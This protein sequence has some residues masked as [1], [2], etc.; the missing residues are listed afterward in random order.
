MNNLTILVDYRGA[1]YSS[2]SNANTF[3]SMDL[4]LLRSRFVS[5]GWDVKIVEFPDIDFQ[6]DWSNEVVLYQSAEDP[7]LEYK[8]YIEDVILG[9][10]LVGARAIPSFPYLRA[11]HNKVFME[12]LRQ[13]SGIPEANTL[14]SKVFGTYEDFVKRSLSYPAVAKAAESSG[15]RGVTL[16]KNP[17]EA[18]SILNRM[19]RSRLDDKVLREHLKRLLRKDYVPYS[20][21]RRKVILQD[22]I[23][24]LTYDY[25]VLVYGKQVYIL[26]RQVRDN[27]FRASGSGKFRWPHE[28]PQGFLDFV[29][30]LFEGFD[31]P[32]AS[33]DIAESKGTF[34][35]LEAQFV[36][37][38]PLTMEKSTFHWVRQVDGWEL[39]EAHSELESTFA[40]GISTYAYK[41]GWLSKP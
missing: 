13:S 16:I 35:L 14:S 30:K 5:I 31:V 21:N 37:F 26:Q 20:L 36:D 12:I 24:D 7:G 10:S 32:N 34:Y 6:K 41:K 29:W 1:F 3:C 22:Y 9:L 19:T 2:T 40:D 38:G 18:T 4:Q 8:S 28:L 11:H 27:D 25:K 39:T 15:S 33:F 23:S 17:K